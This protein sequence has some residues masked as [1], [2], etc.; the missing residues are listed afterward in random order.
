MVDSTLAAR[1]N[2]FLGSDAEPEE[3][4][5]VIEEYGL[6]EAAATILLP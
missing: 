6:S 2:G 4:R 1:I 5:R 3:I